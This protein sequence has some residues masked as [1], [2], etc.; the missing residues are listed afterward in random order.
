MQEGLSLARSRAAYRIFLDQLTSLCAYAA[1]LRGFLSDA[2]PVCRS[3]SRFTHRWICG[4]FC[5]WHRRPPELSLKAEKKYLIIQV[6]DQATLMG[7]VDGQVE[8]PLVYFMK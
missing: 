1:I 4:G 2:V 8:W 7:D 3:C 6:T 5:P